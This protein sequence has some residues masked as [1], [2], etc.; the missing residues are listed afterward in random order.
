MA[1]PFLPALPVLP[2]LWT[3][4]WI[5]FGASKFNTNFTPSTSK[6]L[7]AKSVAI[8]TSYLRFLNPS[9]AASLYY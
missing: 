1:S 9:T 4:S 5:V 7:L 8:N 6:P 3:K 2:V